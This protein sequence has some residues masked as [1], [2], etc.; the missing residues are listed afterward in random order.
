MLL[1]NTETRISFNSAS[2][3][4]FFQLYIHYMYAVH[5]ICNRL[6]GQ[7]ENSLFVPFCRF[8]PLLSTSLVVSCAVT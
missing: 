5:V 3:H 2:P 4:S 7:C 8:M 6:L 1:H